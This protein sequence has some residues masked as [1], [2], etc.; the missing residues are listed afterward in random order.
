MVAGM[1]F[2]SVRDIGFAQQVTMTNASLLRR[3]DQI[4]IAIASFMRRH[5]MYLLRWSIGIVFIWFGALKYT[6]YSPAADLVASTVTLIPREIFLPIL[7]TWEVLI[8]I[9]LIVRPLVRVA[10]ALLFAQMGGTF[11]PL[12]LLPHVCFTHAPWAPTIEGQY[13][14]KNLVIIA[15]ALVIGGSVRDPDEARPIRYE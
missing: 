11:L 9:G 2:A 6:P 13:I 4:D 15:A 8:G 1:A 14:L 7:A 3:F 12:V 5:G 10:I